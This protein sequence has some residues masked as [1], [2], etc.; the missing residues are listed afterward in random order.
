VQAYEVVWQALAESAGLPASA[1]LDQRGNHDVFDTLRNTGQD[2]FT[3]HSA[4]AAAHGSE[5]AAAIR[6]RPWLLP[7]QV[8]LN[9][10][11]H[12]HSRP[13]HQPQS[14]RG[15]D[16]RRL[17]HAQ[18]SSS[19]SSGGGS[20]SSNASSPST[21]AA[22]HS[23]TCQELAQRVACSCDKS[24]IRK[25]A[26]ARKA[27]ATAAVGELLAQEDGAG[28]EVVGIAAGSSDSSSNSTQV[29]TYVRVPTRSGRSGASVKQGWLDA[30]SGTEPS[31]AAR[32]LQAAA[33]A[34]AA[35][36]TAAR[37]PSSSPARPGFVPQRGPAGPSK[38]LWCCFGKP[39]GR[40]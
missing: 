35:T 40:N 14:N 2:L 18:H 12:S 26:Q 37:M 13:D 23:T 30:D 25:A 39:L 7:A 15:R 1:V 9:P 33:A 3:F 24:F 21:A 27:Y 11:S 36:T 10:I 22:E 6:V 34:A 28:A 5:A 19:S 16:H 4:T 17:Q 29:G 38:L 31:S 8:L 32:S 20:G